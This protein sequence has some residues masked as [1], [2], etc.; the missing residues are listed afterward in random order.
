MVAEKNYIVDLAFDTWHN[1]TWFVAEDCGE[2]DRKWQEA[3]RSLDSVGDSCTNSNEFMEKAV[4]HFN[5]YGFE[6]IRK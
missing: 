1:Q 2:N 3:L 6:R 4:E 5:S